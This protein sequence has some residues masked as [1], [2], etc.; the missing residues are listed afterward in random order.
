MFIRC[1]SRSTL[2]TLLFL[3]IFFGIFTVLMFSPVP[4]LYATQVRI[5]EKAVYR[6]A[7]ALLDDVRDKCG[8]GPDTFDECYIKALKKAGAN[9]AVIKFIKLV[10]EPGYVR[11]FQ[12]IGPVD[13]V[14]ADFPF[15]A[16]ENQGIYI[17]NGDP[18]IINVD[19]LPAIKE[20]MLEH[21]RSYTALKKK[22]PNIALW[23]GDRSQ[24]SIEHMKEGKLRIAVP[25]RL[26]NGCRACEGLGT[27]HIGFDFDR[28]GKFEGRK[29][30]DVSPH[31]PK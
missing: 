5:S 17:V 14:F 21:N 23:I 11:E 20:S 15:R 24:V 1:V 16:N 9:K 18:R 22:Y 31:L 26:T 4:Y 29:L 28:A 8:K 27:V 6:P 13:V 30:I 12:E 10:N 7:P 25:Y 3:V 19:D 2:Q